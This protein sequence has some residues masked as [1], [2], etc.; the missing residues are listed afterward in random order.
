MEIGQIP[1]ALAQVFG[2]PDENPPRYRVEL[3][4]GA[5]ELRRYEALTV[6]KTT[7]AGEDVAASKAAFRRLNDYVVGGNV[8]CR[9][10]PCEAPFLSVCEN[11][12]T[13]LAIVMPRSEEAPPK[14]I[15]SEV[16]LESL[17]SR[18]VA[19]LAFSGH[20][21]PDR[22]RE[23]TAALLL[24]LRLKGLEPRSET[25]MARLDSRFTLPWLRR[26]E[27]HVDVA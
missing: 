13:T 24:W 8:A 15:A 9:R 7:L 1:F 12:C 18:R 14:P 22:I 19:S 20:T 5:M 6:A 4:E 11:G 16:E 17:P 3:T 26:H 21:S 23:R 10:I 2:G 25:P 27:V